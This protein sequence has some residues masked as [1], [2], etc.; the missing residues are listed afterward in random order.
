MIKKILPFFIFFAAIFVSLISAYFSI[1]GL[2]KLFAGAGVE[3]MI[4]G[5]SL[6]VSKL[7][8]ATLLYEYWGK[9]SNILK[10]YLTLAVFVL[11]SISSIG[12]YGFLSSAYQETANLESIFNRKIELIDS[13]QS[14]FVESREDLMI[15]RDQVINSITELRSSLGSNQVQYIDRETGQLITTTSAANRT[16]IENQLRD[17]IDRRDDISMRIQSLNDSIGKYDIDKIELQNHSE[18]SS[19]LATLY[20]I[21]RII[22]MDMDI[23]VNYFILLI[24]VVFDPLAVALVIST[25]FSMKNHSISNKSV[26]NESETVQDSNVEDKT[27]ERI[28]TIRKKK[29]KV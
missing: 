21:S 15:E 9:L 7:V 23:V 29:V 20:Y 2:T 3:V 1:L 26:I 11:I 24:V 16:S 22:N 18:S 8:I 10:Y 28:K 14:I 4:M 12:I 19:E 13:R 5:T 27:L 6:E 25:A 17:A